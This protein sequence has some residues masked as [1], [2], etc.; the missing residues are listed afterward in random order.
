MLQALRDNPDDFIDVLCE[1]VLPALS[2]KHPSIQYLIDS[3]QTEYKNYMADLQTMAMNAV[4]SLQLSLPNASVRKAYNHN[5]SFNNLPT[6]IIVLCIEGLDDTGL[7]ITPAEDGLNFTI[8]GTPTTPGTF[9]ARLIYTFQGR[10]SA[11]PPLERKLSL[12][13]NPDPRDLWKNIET[14]TSIPY[15]KPDTQDDYV[16]VEANEHGPQKDIVAASKRGR[17]HAHEGKARDDHFKLAHLE[18]GWYIMAVADGAGSARYSREGSRIACET[19]VNLCAEALSA[20]E[21]FEDHIRQ[22]HTAQTEKETATD[23]ETQ[24]AAEAET[25]C[26]PTAASTN[27]VIAHDV[28]NLLATAAYKAHLAI[29]EECN[30]RKAEEPSVLLK[31]YATTLLLAVCK[32][33]DFGWCV[34]SFWVG[35]GAICLYDKERR[36]AKILGQPDEGEFAGQTRF[37]TMPEIFTNSTELVGR[38]RYTLADDFTALFLMSDGVSD[39]K[40]ETDANLARIE[41]WDTL[42]D[43]LLHNDEH[44]VDLSDDNKDAAPQLLDWLDFWSPGNHDDR[45]IAILY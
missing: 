42:W 19:V 20:P 28:Y 13:I 4:E 8:S 29:K 37:L 32:K 34:A 33:F 9:E 27:T 35:D 38:L 5:L 18:N 7:L 40:F 15:Y 24:A 23:A 36:T 17:S 44:P 26:Q 2:A 43:D 45:T 11:L 25:D 6:N 22:W 39:P 3:H 16:G 10:P 41:K 30:A 31:H 14:D 21:A 1:A 12:I